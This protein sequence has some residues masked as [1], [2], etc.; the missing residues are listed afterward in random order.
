M[1][2][3]F[4]LHFLYIFHPAIRPGLVTPEAGD[5]RPP[6]GRPVGDSLSYPETLEGKHTQL[7]YTT[8]PG[9]KVTPVETRKPKIQNSFSGTEATALRAAAESKS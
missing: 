5:Q 6:V 7:Y 3:H 1:I 9:G 4:F 2:T 8:C